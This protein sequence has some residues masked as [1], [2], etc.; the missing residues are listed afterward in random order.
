MDN[1]TK[2]AGFW[3]RAIADFI[4]SL[5]LD[6]AAILLELMG[7]G[8][9]FW[10]GILSHSGTQGGVTSF[11]EAI[12]PFRF[13]IIFGV[14]RALLSLGYYTW[15]TYRYGTT[16]GKRVLRIYVVS[17]VDLSPITLRQSLIRCLGYILSYLPLGAGFLMAAFHPEKRA[18]HDL[19]AGT[20]SIVKPHEV[21]NEL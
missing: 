13:Q 21:K 17:M 6:S 10:I 7:V 9:L 8:V 2:Y 12:D 1:Q 5:I 19:I 3:I 16:L 18:L 4:D 15:L 14:L 20:V 11:Y